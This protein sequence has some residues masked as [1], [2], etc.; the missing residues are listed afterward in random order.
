[1]KVM[2]NS[3][4]I[5]GVFDYKVYPLPDNCTYLYLRCNQIT[6]VKNIPETCTTLH[7][8]FNK[9]III[10]ENV[11]QSVI[12]LS[13]PNNLIMKIPEY[14]GLRDY[15][16]LNLYHNKINEIANIP[17][18]IRIL[19]LQH[20]KI[21]E[22][23]NIPDSCEILYLASNKITEIKNIP[24]NCKELVLFSNK[25]TEI[26]GIPQNCVDVDLGDNPITKISQHIPVTMNIIGVDIL[27]DYSKQEI[28]DFTQPY[29]LYKLLIFYKIHY[30]IKIIK[31]YISI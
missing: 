14:M 28:S 17:Y 2:V 20:N 4:D 19:N 16:H 1:M 7:L 13:I 27:K 24:R 25:I 5:V 29:R 11:P 6:N 12:V 22:I 10:P 9:I 23:Q 21:M 8:A 18:N 26:K 31:S 15:D 30:C 3:R